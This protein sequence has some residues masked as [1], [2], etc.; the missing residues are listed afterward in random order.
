ML[1]NGE[2]KLASVPQVLCLLKKS[3]CA[4]CGGCAGAELQEPAPMLCVVL[5]EHLQ[6]KKKKTQHLTQVQCSEWKQRLWKLFEV[7]CS[8]AT[9]KLQCACSHFIVLVIRD[10]FST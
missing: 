9:W 2:M 1:S 6:K 8:C 3:N 4:A 7:A 5:R 10:V